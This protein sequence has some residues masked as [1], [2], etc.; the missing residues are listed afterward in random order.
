MWSVKPVPSTKLSARA[1]QN[2]DEHRERIYRTTDRLFAGLLV[3]QY[4]AGI[5]AAFWISPRTW[6]GAHSEWHIHVCAAIVLG[7]AIVSF[8][9]LLAYLRPG[10]TITRHTIAVAQMLQSALLI[11]L[12]GG[13]IET[14]FHVFGSLAF[15]AFYRDWRVLIS[16]SVIVAT[17]HCVRGLVWPQSV[18]GVLTASSWRWVEHAAWVVFEDLFLI[19]ACVKST[20]E[21]Q[22]IAVHQAELEQTNERVEAL[23]RE[24]TAALENSQLQLAERTEELQA[25]LGGAVDAILTIDES[26]EIQTAN[27][28]AEKTF[29]Y[30]VDE[31]VGTNVRR[32]MPE[33]FSS[34]HDQYLRNYRES[35][36]R[37]VIGIGREVQALRRDG[38]MFPA[39]LAVSEVVLPNRRLFTGFVRDITDRQQ[40]Q[41]RETE[42]GRLLE[43]SLTEVYVFHAGSLKFL[44]VNR[45]ARANLGYTMEE[46][47]ELT[48]VDLK[49]E[50]SDEAFDD[51]VAS[52]RDGKEEQ[53]EFRTVHQRKDGSRYPVEVHLQSATFRGQPVF[54][55]NILDITERE[56]FEQSLQDAKADAELA[57][58]AKS[59]FLANMSH[60]IRTPMNGIIGM[61]AI[62]LETDL[63]DEQRDYL[64]TINSSADS[65]L[66]IINDI[67]DFSKIEAGKL[68]LDPC[69]FALRP[70]LGD[71][72]KTMAIR[73]HEKELELLWHVEPNVPDYLS[74]DSGRLRQVLVNLVGNGIKFTDQG[75]IFAR[76]VV[77]SSTEQ[78][79]VLHFS[80]SDS[81]CGIPAEKQR[82]IFD[83]FT[84]ADASTTRTHGGTGLGL[85]ISASLV[86]LMGGQI[87]VVSE[88][89]QGSTFHFTM[90]LQRANAP[91]PQEPVE[92]VSLSGIRVLVTDDNATNRKIL[93]EL[94]RDWGMEPTLTES[95][96]EALVCLQRAAAEKSPYDLILTDCHMPGRDGFDLI[97]RVNAD[98][99]FSHPVIMMLTSAVRPGTHQ[100]CRDLGVA[101]TLLKPLRPEE[102]RT[103]IAGVLTK[104][105]GAGVPMTDNTLQS[106]HNVNAAQT[107]YRVLLAED[108]RVN[109]KVATRILS[110]AGHSVE[111]AEN[112][113]AA[114][115]AVES[116][117]FDLVLMDVQMPE[118]DGL[119]A[120]AIIRDREQTTGGHLPIIAMT[121]H[122]MTGDRERCIQAGMD[123]YVSKPVQ[124]E[125]LLT[126]IAEVLDRLQDRKTDA[127]QP[128]LNREAALARVD[129][130]EEFLQELAVDMLQSLDG[131]A[132]GIEAAISGE[133][134]RKLMKAAHTLRG[135]AANFYAQPLVD[136][137]ANVEQLG[138][139]ADLDNVAA[140]HAELKANLEQFRL[141]LTQLLEYEC[142]ERG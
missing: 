113:K 118:M 75:E 141:E 77:E 101:A 11:H 127:E 93:E 34:E 103:A 32:L 136:A 100:R 55:A 36:E 139:V 56:S 97:D 5:L 82:L 15:L 79:V 12:T 104:Q 52:V 81:G 46:L 19:W 87:W 28:S 33:P 111:I 62:A 102:L 29:G 121:A 95:V 72:L 71:T 91:V 124:P 39:D 85:A 18:F 115:A 119:T 134:P 40:A 138:R 30:S 135:S 4:V 35:N 96:D 31:L 110:R 116:G 67:L 128:F 89:G 42:L 10:R 92:N 58:Q 109:Q 54:V 57:S 66:T 8:P 50:I 88:P 131:L 61:A 20:Q 45:G 22:Q 142:A 49:P 65:L 53:L 44:Q 86:R 98:D 112:G 1:R 117:D 84:Q 137:A 2:Y 70:V 9:L 24:R 48:P 38:T 51:L 76:C 3:V 41:E 69:D 16:A 14:H 78:D 99:E 108:H 64:E 130:D 122:A 74:G 59:E 120:T 26:G 129:G 94:L 80:V 17:D 126:K 90:R 63:S 6:I 21:M 13:R 123:D 47:R 23:V 25:I 60:E 27:A 140:P 83:A 7:A 107:G 43:D 106:S 114:V 68:E 132:E 125:T 105:T 37:K 73:A 133:D